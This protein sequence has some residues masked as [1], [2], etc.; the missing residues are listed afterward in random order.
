MLSGGGDPVLADNGDAASAG[1]PQGLSWSYEMD[2]GA[3]IAAITGADPPDPDKPETTNFQIFLD[4]C[5]RWGSNP[6]PS[7]YRCSHAGL[8][9]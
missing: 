3:L 9:A 1:A 6:R 8:L 5:R 4:R 7:D 2:F